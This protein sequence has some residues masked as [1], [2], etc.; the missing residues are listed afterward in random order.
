MHSTASDGVYSPQD[1]VQIALTHQMDVI[2]L[3]DHDSVDGVLSAQNAA[4]TIM[5]GQGNHIHP[6]HE[7]DLHHVGRLIDTVGRRTV[8]MQIDTHGYEAAV[9]M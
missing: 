1:V 3:T 7:R 2:A 4:Y 8:H 5:I 9:S 6:V